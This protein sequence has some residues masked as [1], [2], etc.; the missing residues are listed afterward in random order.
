[1][2][3]LIE[4][5]EFI[6]L[7]EL[8]PVIDVRSPK[9][10]KHAHIPGAIN[11]PLFDDNERELIGTLYKNE[12]RNQAILAGL[13]RTG[14][15]LVKFV[16]QAQ[17]AAPGNKLL[18]HCWRGGL[19]SSSMAWLLSTAGLDVKVLNGGYKSY[20]RFARECF[21]Q[22][23]NIII[24][25]GKTGSG[26]TK[27]LHEIEALNEQVLDLERIARHKG[28]AFGA[29]GQEEQC[30][31]EQF[32][33]LLFDQWYKLDLSRPVW[34]EDESQ[35][36]G[37]IRIPSEIFLQMRQNNLICINLPKTERIAMLLEEYGKFETGMLIDSVLKIRKRLGG[38]LTSKAIEA[39]QQGDLAFAIDVSLDYYDKAYAYGLSKRDQSNVHHLEL[40]YANP[41]ENA[42]QVLRFSKK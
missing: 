11:I 21:Q 7:R 42:L 28:S 30:S 22:K 24:L 36:I 23:A 15:K 33:N 25:G 13:E 31:N 14:P 9:E 19:R 39:I 5:E 40:E 29:L 16:R 8:T 1:M 2:N 4:I 3:Q 41:K 18:L 37:K 34:I 26:K 6:A 17:Q 20:R 27:I 12:G 38:L 35:A 10:Y 32:E